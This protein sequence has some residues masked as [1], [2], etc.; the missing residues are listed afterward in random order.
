MTIEIQPAPAV[1]PKKERVNSVEF[2]RFLFTAMVAVYHLEIFY[3]TLQKRIP[4]GSTAVE[5][6]FILAG[7]TTAMSASRRAE[8]R[9]GRPIDAREA[10]AL[11]VKYVK[12]KL[13]AIY[14]ILAVT[15]ALALVVIPA[16]PLL[17]KLGRL[18]GSEWEW[19][20][21]V[22]TP[23]GYNNGA[24][25]LVPLWFLTQL[26]VVGYIYTFL[27]N[28][29]RDFMM[30]AAPAIAVL[31]YTFFTLNSQNI[32]DF[33]VKMGFFNAG[34]VHAFSEMAMGI[35]LYQLYA[36]LKK[37]GLS[38]RAVILLTVVEL[39]AIYRYFSMTFTQQVGLDNFRRI[40]YVMIIV[41]TSFLNVTFVSKFLNGAV[42]RALGRISLTMYLIHFPLATA[43]FNMKMWTAVNFMTNP[44][45]NQLFGF[46]NGMGMGTG[47]SGGGYGAPL[48]LRDAF[49]YI[50]FV[51][52]AAAL[53]T[54]FL[55]AVRAAAA[56]VR[57]RIEDRY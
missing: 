37:R 53:I 25:P 44:I 12:D 15:L 19:L 13:T 45:A 1:A 36:Y 29:R 9:S 33:Y 7:F 49:V 39:Y 35:A 22:G 16:G 43:F 51:M 41:L 27:I 42:S 24:A 55:A 32:L 48:G 5:F 50:V 40:P 26:L 56:Q 34:A 31:G 6:F 3:M 38:R 8:A 23:M 21:M 52:I 30:F 28:I 18:F 46:F 4:S 54:L 17:G 14:P 2:W 11:A 10:H 20:F 47:G 57:R